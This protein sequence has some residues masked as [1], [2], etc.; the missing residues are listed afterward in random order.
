MIHQTF[1]RDRFTWLAYFS[2]AVYGYFLNVLG[3]ITPF[4]KAELDLTYTVSS[5][6][7]TAFAIGILF[8]GV[9]GHVIIQ[10]IGHRRALWLGL[11]G[12]SL[13]A[14]FLLLGRTPLV[15]I[16]ASFLMGLIGSLILAIVP[17]ALSDQ[18]GEMK[19]VALSEANVTA[20]L[21]ATSAPLL[22]GWFADSIGW[23]WALGLMAC[24]PV[25]MF[26]GLGKNSSPLPSSKPSGTDQP[27]QPLPALFWLYWVALVLGVSVEFC[28]VFWSADYMEQVLGLIKADAAQAVSLFLAAMIA[29]RMLGSRLVQ[30]F[31]TRAVVAVSILI[32]GIGFLLFW[33]AENGLLG[34]SGLFITGLGVANLYPLILS[35]AINAANGNTI[36][37]GARAT[38]ASGTAILALPLAL[39]RLADAVGIRSAYSIVI[40]LLVSVFL[41][42]QIARRIPAAPRRVNNT[43]GGT[44][45]QLPDPENAPVLRTDFS[46]QA[47]WEKICE[48]IQEPVGIFRF[49]AN[50]EFLDDMEYVGMSTN[51]LLELLPH[52]Y[53]HNFIIIVDRA[54][55]SLPEHPLLIV[56]LYERS[57]HEFRAIPSTIQSIENN[58]SIGNMDFEEFAEAAGEDGV[59]R[60]FPNDGQN[61]WLT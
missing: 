22:V 13:S 57:G 31:S 34:L 5:F 52:D 17:A 48:E 6:H 42:S 4:L 53:N 61:P 1:H 3:P 7:F 20:S 11:F 23:R 15:T 59:F 47:S 29:G 32:A 26:L 60:G 18:H 25:L 36:Q 16:G 51:E 38:L 39:G 35:L 55:V 56:D 8:I 21:L 27:S 50:V 40:A 46:D 19:A 33:R 44:M 49:R 30:R 14:L 24:I 54:A 45:K 37:A 43:N 28:M 10:R 58:L 41:I 9:G 2:L 12:M